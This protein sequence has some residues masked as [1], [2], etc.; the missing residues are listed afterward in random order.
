MSVLDGMAQGSDRMAEYQRVASEASL[1]LRRKTKKLEALTAVLSPVESVLALSAGTADGN[2]R[3]NLLAL[4]DRRILIL[5][6]DP[7]EAVSLDLGRVMQITAKR[8][9]GSGRIDILLRDMR[10]K[11]S[12]AHNDSVVLFARR[13]EEA[14][15]NRMEDELA[16]AVHPDPSIGPDQANPDLPQNAYATVP[17][18]QDHERLEVAAPALSQL[19]ESGESTD[20]STLATEAAGI[21]V[22]LDI[23]DAEAISRHAREYGLHEKSIRQRIPSLLH[24]L[25]LNEEVAFLTT[26]IEA[27]KDLLIALTDRRIIWSDKGLEQTNAVDLAELSAISGQTGWSGTGRILVDFGEHHRKFGVV[28]NKTIDPFVALTRYAASALEAPATGAA[29]VRVGLDIADAAAISRHAWEYG[30]GEG[31]IRQRIPSLLHAL[32]PNEEVAFL[33]TGVEANKTVLIALTDRRIIWSDKDLEQTNAIDLVE[34]STISG[35]TGRLESGDIL[36]DFDWHRR[37]FGWVPNKTIDPFVSLTRDAASAL[38]AP[39]LS[40]LEESGESTDASTPAT[41]AAGIRVRLDI[42]DAEAINRHAREYGIRERIIHQRIPSLLHALDHLNEEVVFLTSGRHATGDVL[43]ALTDRYIIWSDKGLEQ[44]NAIDLVELS[45]ISGQTG[46]LGSGHILVVFDGHHRKFDVVPNET[47]DPFVAL[48]R[49]AASALETPATGAAGIR[50]RLDIADAE[51]ISRYAREYGIQE[52]TIRQRIPSLLHA[53]DPNEGVVFLTTGV[54]ANKTVLIVLTD[55]R[56]VW[57]DKDPQQTNT[58]DLVELST[59]SGQTGRLGSGHILVDFDWHRRKF[60]VV[61]NE[62]I[63]LFVALTRDAASALGAPATEADRTV[64]PFKPVAIKELSDQ[65]RADVYRRLATEIGDSRLMTRGELDHLP[66]VMMPDE[67]LL[68]FA[69]GELQSTGKEQRTGGFALVALT[70]RRILILDKKF[71]AGIQTIAIDLDRVNSITGDTGLF[72]G[73]VKIQDGGDERKVG[74]IRNDTVQ[75][76]VARVQEAIQQRKQHLHDQQAAAIA[77]ASAPTTA[78]PAAVNVA[79]QLEKLAS[80]ME[81]GILTPEEFAQQKAKL[82]QG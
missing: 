36:V 55:R 14:R 2:V 52:G 24:A 30:L 71:L 31:T 29:G 8:G 19:E 33:T 5:K 18:P 27:N 16:A 37:K 21:R 74:L 1:S 80:L 15:R 22:R 13:A 42:A 6:D 73:N 54:E 51:A 23:A 72:F 7:G 57:S 78:P 26:G 35:Q 11:I 81:R 66:T 75:P 47:I 28:P 12:A 20:A 32:D 40:Q 68:W 60:D 50:F 10:M 77:A 25:D 41:E 45:T 56:I 38:E 3:E 58:I 61:P 4:T 69:S 39:A 53:L 43:I 67:L 62:T 65:D 49:D 48:T 76:F 46:G 63:D 70:D 79:D 64:T 34:L 17:P 44:T 59:I 82:L 9:M